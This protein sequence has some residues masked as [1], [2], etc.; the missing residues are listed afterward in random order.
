MFLHCLLLI[1]F[2]PGCFVGAATL[3][4]CFSVNKTSSEFFISPGGYDPS[5]LDHDTCIQACAYQEYSYAALRAGQICLCS[6]T[7]YSP[8]AREADDTLCSTL[9]TGDALAKCGHNDY[10]LVYSIADTRAA[11]QLDDAV[12][13][14]VG[15]GSP[16]L[17]SSAS[18]SNLKY[19][20]DFGDG[21]AASAHN[22]HTYT[23]PGDYIVSVIVRNDVSVDFDAFHHSVTTAVSGATVT[24]PDGA[25]VSQ[26]FECVVEILHGN[27][28]S[29]TPTFGSGAEAVMGPA[30]PAGMPTYFYFGHVSQD[31]TLLLSS[32]D[33]HGTSPIFWVFP[34]LEILQ[35]SKLVA[36]EAAIASVG[37]G[38][39]HFVVYKPVCASPSDVYCPLDNV[40]MA[41]SSCSYDFTLTTQPTQQDTCTAIN[42][43]FCS[44]NTRCMNSIHIDT[45]PS[46][47]ARY[48]T[49]PLVNPRAEYEIVEVW[50]WRLTR[51]C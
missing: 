49:N 45:C 8:A 2:L 39:L 26:E 12:A 16:V 29:V 28:L 1:V 18:G 46:K 40:C 33:I 32:S 41:A 14:V 4:G 17:T 21:T 36:I 11:I 6:D 51:T 27:N 50:R 43:I 23:A 35:K 37:D 15:L 44:S 19:T 34:G 20:Y 9:C 22:S 7:N 10:A 48:E 5:S 42:E 3:E 47:P 30:I 24:C 38:T 25:G 31:P 13:Y